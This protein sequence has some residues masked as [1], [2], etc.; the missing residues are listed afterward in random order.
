MIR[1]RLT[2]MNPSWTS[3]KAFSQGPE[4]AA[5]AVSRAPLG[6]LGDRTHLSS[7]AQAPSTSE[8]LGSLLAGLQAWGTEESPANSN[9]AAGAQETGTGRPPSTV[10]VAILNQVLSTLKNAGGMASAGAL[11]SL[12]SWG[13][14]ELESQGKLR[15]EFQ[16]ILREAIAFA[17]EQGIMSAEDL[18]KYEARLLS[19]SPEGGS[20]RPSG[21]CSNCSKGGLLNKGFAGLKDRNAA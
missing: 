1:D 9:P 17:K 11:Q 8:R 12:L 7:E 15:P 4:S 10:P 18:A 14:S 20:S 2:S 13:S 3:P 6:G 21:G 5:P 16:N 19:P